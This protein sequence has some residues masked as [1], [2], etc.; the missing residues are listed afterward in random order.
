MIRILTYHRVG[1]AHETPWLNPRL[2]SALP[3]A[4]QAQMR[5]LAR[6][7]R[8]VSLDDVLEA[9]DSRKPLPERAVLITFDD[10]YFDF[11][12]IAWPILKSLQLPA[13]VFV[14]TAYPGAPERLFWWDR[15]YHA[16]ASSHAARLEETPIG[17][18]DLKPPAQRMRHLKRLQNHL[19][20]LPHSQAMAEVDRLCERLNPPPP[21]GRGVLDWDELRQLARQGVRLASHTRTHPIMTRLPIAEIRNEI[22][23]SQEDLQ[24]EIGYA[25]PAFSYP[26][27]GHSQPVVALLKELGFK[28]ALTTMDGLNELSRIDPMLLRRTNITPKTTPALFRLRLKRWMMAVDGWRHRKDAQIT[29]A[30][31]LIGVRK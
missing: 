12:Q 26:A 4:F 10:A 20:R 13:T 7:Y 9:L 15:L 18:I 21:G 22:A 23:G 6:H 11:A 17:S 8:V 3:I 2:I 25:P 28:M 1:Y 31:Q 29:T 5:Y 24:R 14:P 27:G 30:G 19:K 16:I